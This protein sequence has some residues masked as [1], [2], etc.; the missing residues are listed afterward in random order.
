M[1]LKQG[2]N[3]NTS[4]VVSDALENGWTYVAGAV[5]GPLSS[6]KLYTIEPGMVA[7]AVAGQAN[8]DGSLYN[9][10]D[11][12]QARSSAR[13][14]DSL[15]VRHWDEYVGQQ[16]NTI[17]TAVLQ[18]SAPHVT[19]RLGRY[20]LLGFKN[21]LK[22]S[23]L[24]SPIPTDGGTNHF[25]V[26]REGI[27]FVARDPDLNPATHTR[28]AAYY[29]PKS[30]LMSVNIAEPIKLEVGGFEGWATS[31]VFS[32]NGRSVAF[33]QM[34][35]DGYESDK[36]GIIIFNNFASTNEQSDRPQ[37]FELLQDDDGKEF[38]DRSPSSV[39]WH[40]SNLLVQA[41]DHGFGCLFEI[42]LV[43]SRPPGHQPPMPRK[44]TSSGYVSQVVPAAA[45]SDKLFVS[46]TNL[47]S[48]SEY[49]ILD[50]SA[51]PDTNTKLISSA[52]Q[53]GSLFGLSSSQVS[54][55][56]WKGANDHPIHAFMIKPSFF[57]DNHK[58][59]LAY[60]IHGGPQGKTTSPAFFTRFIVYEP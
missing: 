11:T 31:P 40:G 42:P 45:N 23:K 39:M 8:P 26:G 58:Y 53:S 51:S 59:P 9:E 35:I 60:L 2:E 55:I 25:D 48:S 18:K 27:V 43:H 5:P 10:K 14:Y 38:W 19:E 28:C 3:G 4:F 33:L 41:E 50:P 22:G 49:F 6:L 21:A 37:G 12:P 13:L 47:V 46:S 20:S 17:W 44:L 1:W 54:S 52:S 32:P 7:V 57:E 15:F 36:N 29:V 30:D 16:R 24:E 34:K 56:W